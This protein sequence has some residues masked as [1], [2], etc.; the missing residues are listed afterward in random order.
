MLAMGPQALCGSK[1]LGL[2]LIGPELLGSELLRPKLLWPE[3][4]EPKLLGPELFGPDLLGTQI[5]GLELSA[6]HHM[7][8]ALCGHCEPTL[9]GRLLIEPTRR[10]QALRE[11]TL[12]N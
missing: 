6:S 3:L 8:A 9:C 4:L 5:L 7:F 10:W 12:R 2:E 1:L 11:T